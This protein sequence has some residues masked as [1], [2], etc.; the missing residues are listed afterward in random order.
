MDRASGSRSRRERQPRSSV[1]YTE[2]PYDGIGA[3]LRQARISL[4]YDIA[5]VA[6]ALRM[7]ASQVEAIEEGRFGDLPGATYAAGF[8]RSYARLLGIDPDLVAGAFR[9][10]AQALRTP[11]KLEFPLPPDEGNRPGLALIV[12]SLVVA[13]AIYGAWHSSSSDGRVE[14]TAVSEVPERLVAAVSELMSPNTAAPPDAE[15]ATTSASAA[16]PEA[17]LEPAAGALETMA[18]GASGAAA[19]PSGSALAAADEAAAGDVSQASTGAADGPPSSA[20]TAATV[21]SDE[22]PD[23]PPPEPETLALAAPAGDGASAPPPL[24]AVAGTSVAAGY[25]PRTFGAA[26]KGARV[27]LRARADSWVQIQGA[28]S[29]LVLTRMLRAGDTYQVPNRDDLV[30]ITGNAGGIIFVVDGKAFPP[31]GPDGAVRRNIPLAPEELLARV[32]ASQ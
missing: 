7:R 26:N 15:V 13:G 31:M 23:T 27:V 21:A 8:L 19:A 5:Q 20:A 28:N 25:V 29:E 18:E 24:P 10:E 32:A 2:T 3:E 1:E 4:G 22:D 30:M 9:D 12:V 6:E 16:V 14:L 17:T 11:P